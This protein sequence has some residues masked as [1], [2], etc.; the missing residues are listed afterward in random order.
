MGLNKLLVFCVL[1]GSHV[2]SLAAAT[3]VSSSKEISDL[4]NKTWVPDS[5]I[6]MSL[7]INARS[8][9][10]SGRCPTPYEILDVTRMSDSSYLI[11]IRENMSGV[12]D[13]PMI[14]M[15][16]CFSDGAPFLLLQASP[17]VERLRL[18]HCTSYGLL[19]T[20]VAYL[21]EGDSKSLQNF[22]QSPLTCRSEYWNIVTRRE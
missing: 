22:P 6:R 3:S 8:I 7:K 21:K 14:G 2:S 11:E 20:I 17:P 18:W 15:P 5:S 10:F 19:K 13:A 9:T 16:G 1:F 12:Q 4:Y